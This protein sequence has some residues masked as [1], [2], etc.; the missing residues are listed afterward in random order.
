MPT[1]D[2]GRAYDVG[3]INI[4]S[5]RGSD[6]NGIRFADNRSAAPT[7]ANDFVLYRIS[8]SL[9]FS[10]AGTEYNLLTSVSGSVGDLNGVYENGSSIGID[11]GPIILTDSTSGAL[12][13]L[14]LTKSGAGSRD[15]F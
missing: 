12:D 13:M 3:G 6:L 8:D 14:R 1:Y 9:R 7:S 10:A 11:E 4:R 2:S 15:S 5:R